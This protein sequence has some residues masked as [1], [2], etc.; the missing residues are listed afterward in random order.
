MVHL[1]ICSITNSYTTQKPGHIVY[2]RCNTFFWRSPNFHR[3]VCPLQ[4]VSQAV[5]PP[6]STDGF[7]YFLLQKQWI[8]VLK[9]L[10]CFKLCCYKYSL[11]QLPV[12]FSYAWCS[13]WFWTVSQYRSQYIRD[14]QSLHRHQIYNCIQ[15]SITMSIYTFQ[16]KNSE[17]FRIVSLKKCRKLLQSYIHFSTQ[18]SSTTFSLPPSSSFPHFKS[19]KCGFS[20]FASLSP[21]RRS[22]RP[23]QS[24]YI[25]SAFH[26]W[27]HVS[28]ELSL[29]SQNLVLGWTLLFCLVC[30][31][32]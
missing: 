32:I 18:K 29:Y 14:I 21:L 25:M 28:F 10:T 27:S 16:T 3:I 1:V 26:C 31:R 11:N 15:T 20:Q 5:E 19:G 9:A 6:Q 2:W 8:T 7:T 13:P 4:L 23:H 17:T 30:M 22:V 12:C 24:P